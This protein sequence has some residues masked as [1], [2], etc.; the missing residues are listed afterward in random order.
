[1]LA[2]FGNRFGF[3]EDGLA[4]LEYSTVHRQHWFGHSNPTAAMRLIGYE[5]H[6]CDCGRCPGQPG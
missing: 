4:A 6:R 2:R 3:E 5:I 1:M